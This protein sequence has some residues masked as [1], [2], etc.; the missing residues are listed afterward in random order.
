MVLRGDKI[1]FSRDSDVPYTVLADSFRGDECVFCVVS[2]S[3]DTF[4]TYFTHDEILKVWP[5]R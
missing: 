5:R 2:E 3:G 4:I 1:A